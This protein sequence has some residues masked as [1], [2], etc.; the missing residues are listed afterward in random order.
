MF[1]DDF[2]RWLEFPG[3]R[4]LG[5][6]PICRRL[7]QVGMEPKQVNVR[8]SGARTTRTTWVVLSGFLPD[9]NAE[10]GQQR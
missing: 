2:R 8:V 9:R 5:K 6:Y 7:R 4:Q 10:R 3:G 1:V